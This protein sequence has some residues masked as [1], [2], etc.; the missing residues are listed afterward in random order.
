MRYLQPN[1]TTKFRMGS[2]LPVAIAIACFVAITGC[3]EPTGPRTICCYPDPQPEQTVVALA[4]LAAE[5]HDAADVFAQGVTDVTLRSNAEL[6]VN[7]L[8]DRFLTGKVPPSRAALAQ[9]RAV[10]ANPDEIS[11]IEIAPVILA[12]D[13]VER[14]MNQILAAIGYRG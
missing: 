3:G 2:R 11:A 1:R 12:L 9:A 4:A 8:A 6:A 13:H 7:S 5:L 10:L 14:R